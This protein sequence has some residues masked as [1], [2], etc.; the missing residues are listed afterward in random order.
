MPSRATPK[1]RIEHACDGI[2][3]STVIDRCLSLLV[4]GSEDPDFIVILGGAPAVRL[5]DDG[6]PPGQDY[7]LR[8]WAARGLLWAGPGDDIGPLRAALTDRSWRV[9]EM[10]C[11]VVT[12]HRVGDLLND[13]AVLESD[14]VLRVRRAAVRAAT[15]IVGDDAL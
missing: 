11:K 14:P 10:V 12:R 3:R 2:G 8:V 1:L 6:I 13:V 15:R 5:L 7:W 9:R 4:G